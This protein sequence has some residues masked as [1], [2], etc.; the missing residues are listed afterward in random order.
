MKQNIDIYNSEMKNNPFSVPEDYFETSALKL[1][2]KILSNSKNFDTPEDYFETNK[3]KLFE[4]ITSTESHSLS[5]PENYFETNKSHLIHSITNTSSNK[6]TKTRII[7]FA[8]YVSAAAIIVGIIWSIQLFKQDINHQPILQNDCKTIAC[9]T[10]QD[11]LSNENVLDEE[12]IEDNI[13]DEL[14]DS[15]FQNI[16][17][18]QSTPDSN[19]SQKL[20]ET[21]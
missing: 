11:I 1:K 7:L 14:I 5:I 8:K 10:K 13:S 18:S 12:I 4:T 17:S 3:L 6:N 16:N 21:F 2:E 20:N 15:H 9:L 19:S